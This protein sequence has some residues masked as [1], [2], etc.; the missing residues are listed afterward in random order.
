M[1]EVMEGREYHGQVPG[2]GLGWLKVACLE[3]R[4]SQLGAMEY[5]GFRAQKFHPMRDREA[6]M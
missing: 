6:P 4:G 1:G 2:S 3:G 5:C